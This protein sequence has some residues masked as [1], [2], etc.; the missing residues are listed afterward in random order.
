MKTKKIWFVFTILIILILIIYVAFNFYFS[1]AKILEKNWNVIVPVG[2]IKLYSKNGLIDFQ[3]HGLRYN[4]FQI[5]NANAAILQDLSDGKNIEMEK[6]V[7]KI[8]NEINADKSKYNIFLNDYKWKILLK[9]TY[10]L[11]IV[12]DIKTSIIYL[13]Q[14]IQ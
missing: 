5:K 3:G 6:N 12:Y 11:Y 2:S 13:I 10:K 4:V 7:D 9:Y 1:D 8:L 14:D